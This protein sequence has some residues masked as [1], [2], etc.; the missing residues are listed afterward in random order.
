MT[1]KFLMPTG[2]YLAHSFGRQGSF[3]AQAKYPA[4]SSAESSGTGSWGPL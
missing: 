3:N 1:E 4:K 2:L